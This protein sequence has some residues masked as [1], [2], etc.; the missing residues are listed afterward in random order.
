VQDVA[1]DTGVSCRKSRTGSGD[2]GEEEAPDADGE[3]SLAS[4]DRVWGLGQGLQGPG[5]PGEEET[6]NASCV[7]DH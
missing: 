4:A 5:D 3:A 1:R 2:Q 7:S 6:T